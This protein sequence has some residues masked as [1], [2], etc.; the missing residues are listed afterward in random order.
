MERR[1][2][3]AIEVEA[4]TA[5]YGERTILNGVNLTVAR[6]EVRVILGGSGCGKSTLLRHLI[7]LAQPAEG[8][9]RVLGI[10][11]S[12]AEEEE[13]AEVSRRIGMLFQGGALLNGFTIADNVAL[14][15]REG[16]EL[17]EEVIA[18]IV[19]MKLALVNLGHA[20]QLYP[21]QLSG[22][23]KKRAALARAMAMDPEILFCDEPSAG[24]DP[25]TAAE[26]DQLLLGL[27]ARFGMTL[28]VVT[29][30]LASVETIADRVVMLDKGVV[31]AEGRLAEVKLMDDPMVRA[32]F[33]RAAEA[34]KRGRTVLE[35]LSGGLA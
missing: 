29:H 9:I 2:H 3:P 21:P 18:E 19:Q 27:K 34:E 31:R 33:D 16:T 13:R 32:F 8:R 14:P 22:G 10:E 26:L 25:I 7:G 1:A 30:E 35:A 28:V 4:L 12:R 20:A 24:L 11:L 15:L 6:G 23:M 17:P 5:R